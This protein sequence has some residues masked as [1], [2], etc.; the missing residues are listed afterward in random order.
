MDEAAVFKALADE[1]RRTLL[2]LLFEQDGRTLTDLEGHLEMTRFGVMKHLKVLEDAGLVATK[3]QG[4]EKLHFLNPVPIA[5]VY[6]RWVDKYTHPHV[7]VL[8]GLKS[9]LET[10][11]M[12]QTKTHTHVF[13][14]HIRA[15]VDKVWQTLL[16]PDMT[17]KFFFDTRV[18]TDLKPGSAFQYVS[19]DGELMLDGEVVE[20]DP[21]HK[22]VTTFLPK[23]GE[24]AIDADYSKVTY[25]L[26]EKDGVTR[27]R[28]THEGL[29]EGKPVVQNTFAGWS[30]ILAGLKTLLETGQAL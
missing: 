7:R 25:E 11:Q 26:E 29:P 21:P 17:Q 24:D 19:S 20:C 5:T 4:R 23:W 16:D 13:E 10:P 6:D 30:R 3:K 28:L 1:S 8:A 18:T 22:L 14:T 15:S 12:T 27:L 2:D 9:A